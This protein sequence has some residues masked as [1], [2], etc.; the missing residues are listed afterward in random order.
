[1]AGSV[2][3]QWAG[4]HGIA[5]SAGNAFAGGSWNVTRSASGP[6]TVVI[7]EFLAAN[8]TGRL[9]E[10]GDRPAWIEIRNTGGTTVNLVG[11][12]LSTDA[13]EPAQWIFPSR[14]LTPG[15]YM[16]VTASGKDRKP[17][18]GNL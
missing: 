12:S 17:A 7:H 14:A 5:D 13:D 18:A 3:L 9:D 2:A 16:V 1:A 11:W 4:G 8:A 15:A 6:G 10:D